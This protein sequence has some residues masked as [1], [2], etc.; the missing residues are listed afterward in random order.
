[1]KSS[2]RIWVSLIARAYFSCFSIF[3]SKRRSTQA[4]QTR[5]NDDISP[6]TSDYDFLVNGRRFL[7][8]TTEA[9]FLGVLEHEGKY[10]S[11]TLICIDESR[12]T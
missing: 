5:V 9:R 1:M 8:R 7:D 2:K 11:L 3:I 6:F 4:G 10:W 12:K